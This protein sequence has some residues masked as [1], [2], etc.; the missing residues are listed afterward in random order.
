MATLYI[1]IY[2]KLLFLATKMR[3]EKAYRGF[4][5]LAENITII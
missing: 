2:V 4:V 5:P 3:P 1:Q